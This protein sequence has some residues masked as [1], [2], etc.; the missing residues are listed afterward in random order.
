[1]I[2]ILIPEQVMTMNDDDKAQVDRIIEGIVSK[3]SE[4]Y[5]RGNTLSLPIPAMDVGNG[6]KI[7]ILDE[8]ARQFKKAGWKVDYADEKTFYIGAPS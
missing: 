4:E 2:E 3:L 5:Y 7:R 6:R 8:V 1:M